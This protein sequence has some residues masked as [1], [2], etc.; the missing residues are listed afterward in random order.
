MN[1]YKSV[2]VF[3]EQLDAFLAGLTDGWEPVTMTHVGYWTGGELIIVLKK[4]TSD[5]WTCG[6]GTENFAAR[7]TCRLCHR[8]WGFKE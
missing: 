8:T 1:E 5:V 6:C 7:A 2:R 4:A 3:T